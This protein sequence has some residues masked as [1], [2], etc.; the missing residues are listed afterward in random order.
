MSERQ[1]K[2]TRYNQ[3]LDYIAAVSK[4]LEREPPMWR[5]LKRKRWKAEKPT[6]RES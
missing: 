4:W 5:I 3:K 2:K 6:W 1:A